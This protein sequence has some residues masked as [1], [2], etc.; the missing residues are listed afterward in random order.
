MGNSGTKSR[1]FNVES[2]THAVAVMLHAVLK[3]KGH[4]NPNAAVFHLRLHAAIFMIN[5]RS[6]LSVR[7]LIGLG[8]DEP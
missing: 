4:T 1:V 3:K 2:S 5:C 7:P 6:Q 8:K